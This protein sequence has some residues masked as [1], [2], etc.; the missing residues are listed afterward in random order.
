MA[1]ANFYWE[2][3]RLG[4]HIGRKPPFGSVRLDLKEEYNT[5][6]YWIFNEGGGDRIYDLSKEKNYG[7]ITGAIWASS[8]EHG[9][10]LNFDGNDFITLDKDTEFIQNTGIFTLAIIID[11]SNYAA[12]DAS[13]FFGSTLTSNEKGCFIGSHSLILAGVTVGEHAVV[14]AGAIV[15]KD[16]LPYGVYIGCPAKLNRMIK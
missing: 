5:K 11:F 10:Y 13:I 8:P 16:C 12:D 9:K 14:A 4:L 2:R 6:S 15:S 3:K 1:I 7:P